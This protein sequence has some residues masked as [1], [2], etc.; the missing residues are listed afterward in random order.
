MMVYRPIFAK[1]NR[2]LAAALALLA[3]W[4]GWDWPRARPWRSR[5]HPAC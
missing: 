4:R 1:G 2:G 5:R 3:R